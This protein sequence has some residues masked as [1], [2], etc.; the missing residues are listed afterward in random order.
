VTCVA[1]GQEDTLWFGIQLPQKTT[2]K[3]RLQWLEFNESRQKYVLTQANDN[4]SG[5]SICG[6]FHKKV[7]DICADVRVMRENFTQEEIS[8]STTAMR[9][10]RREIAVADAAAA[11]S[12]DHS[13]N[14]RRKIDHTSA[15]LGQGLAQVA[16]TNILTASRRP[17]ST[18]RNSM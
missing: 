9:K 7:F 17:G 13:S 5:S 6:V 15:Q 8:T 10:L 16:P 11:P 4:V 12:P 18:M 2:G 14:K 3:I 1:A